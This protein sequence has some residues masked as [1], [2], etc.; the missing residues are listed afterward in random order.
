M[1][2]PNLA[3]NKTAFA[4]SS[5]APYLPARAVDDLISPLN[6][7]MAS[8][9][10]SWMGV[11]LGAVYWINRWVVKQPGGSGWQSPSYNMCDFKLQGSLDNITWFDIDSVVNNGASTLDRSVTPK[12]ARYVRVYVTKGLQ[13][14]TRVA[15]IMEFE[16]Y[17]ATNAPYLDSLAPSV[18]ML[19]P[20]FAQ[21]Q[22]NY[23]VSVGSETGNIR[24]TPTAAAG[25]IKVNGTVVSSGQLSA[26]ISLNLGNNSV[27]VTVTSSDMTASY[28]VNVIRAGQLPAAKLGDL[29]VVG[30]DG[31][32]KT[33][34]P[35]FGADTFGYAVSVANAVTWVKVTPTAGT[36]TTAIKVNGATIASGGQSPQI[37]LNV[38]SNTIT[39]ATSGSGYLDGVYTIT[40][41]RA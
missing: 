23:S 12:Q 8:G 18:G 36:G 21:K 22:Y 39:V 31:H 25:V 13:I 5:I 29:A 40:V 4:S 32:S 15:A 6:R 9:L 41:T 38:G 10:P 34:N 20:A 17:D 14:N 30:S 26:P 1:T 3:L 24:F 2:M 33:L 7:W 19:S 16:V 37:N 27:T 11:D 35:A 28:A